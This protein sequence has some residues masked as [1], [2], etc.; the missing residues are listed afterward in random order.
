MVLNTAN[1]LGSNFLLIYRFAGY[2]LLDDYLEGP[3]K[4]LSLLYKISDF[5]GNQS[6]LTLTTKRCTDTVSELRLYFYGKH[7]I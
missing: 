4:L 2:F 6:I 3:L 7:Q 5:E 1:C